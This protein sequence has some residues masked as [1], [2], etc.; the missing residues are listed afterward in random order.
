MDI[1]I[2]NV[3][4]SRRR[5]RPADESALVFGKSF[6]DHMFVMDY[7]TGQGWYD[8]R[9]VPYQD[10]CLDPAAMVLHYGQGIFEGMKA[11]RSR[12]GRV[13]LFRPRKNFERMNRSAQRLCMPTIDVEDHL[14]ILETLL[15]TDH[16]W[17]PRSIGSS[18]YIRPTMIASEPHIGVRPADE[19]IYFI[20]KGPVG[21]YYAEGF[22]P[23]SIYVSDEFVRAVRGGVGEAK[24][25]GNYAASLYAAEVA[26]KKGFTQV[27]WLD[28]IERRFIEEVGTMNIF[29]RIKDEL[30][31]PPLTGSILP[32]ITRDSVIALARHWGLSVQERPIDIQECIASIQDGTMQEIFG[33]GTAAVISPVGSISYKDMTY[34][35]LDGNVGEL[36]RRLYDEITGIQYGEKEDVFGWVHEVKI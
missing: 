35:V 36:A 25:M 24:T 2:Q 17:I 18:L 11:Y 29:F 32:G 21:A 23:I 7:R 26:K 4:P 19:Y 20:I 9:V 30:I 13:H 27:L 28:G 12:G 16:D 14:T 10:I 3:I 1:T 8:H 34:T 22:N 33:S 6:T 5:A 31:T 15:R